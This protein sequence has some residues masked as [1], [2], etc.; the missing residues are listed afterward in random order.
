[1]MHAEHYTGLRTHGLLDQKKGNL[2]IL[3][4]ALSNPAPTID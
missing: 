4:Q 3:Q 2:Y 1:M